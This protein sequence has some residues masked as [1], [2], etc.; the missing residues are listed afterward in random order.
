MTPRSDRLRAW[1]PDGGDFHDRGLP[2]DN[3]EC[4]AC[5]ELDSA[6]VVDRQSQD[7]GNRTTMND[8]LAEF[9]HTR[10]SLDALPDGD[11]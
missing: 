1:R 9:G 6:T 7:T 3:D 11:Q 10:E 8:V 4:L 5:Y 2:C